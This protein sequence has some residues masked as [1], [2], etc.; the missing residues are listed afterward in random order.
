[1]PKVLECLLKTFLKTYQGITAGDSGAMPFFSPQ[2]VLR[3]SRNDGPR[4]EIRSQHGE[5]YSFSERHEQV[6]RHAR[7]Q[8][9]GSKHDAD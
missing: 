4:K 2:Q 9:H 3:H 8:E 5:D 7:E 6:S 1:M